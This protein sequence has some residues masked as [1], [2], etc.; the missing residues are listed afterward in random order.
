MIKLIRTRTC[1][2]LLGSLLLGAMFGSFQGSPTKAQADPADEFFLYGGGEDGGG[3]GGGGGSWR[4]P[5]TDIQTGDSGCRS[6][7]CRKKCAD[8]A[9]VCVFYNSQGSH[10]CPPLEQCTNP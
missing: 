3:G 10:L 9:W 8:C 5:I 6:T 7:G 4:C 2:L 1:V